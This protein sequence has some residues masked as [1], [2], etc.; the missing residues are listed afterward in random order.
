MEPEHTAHT[1]NDYSYTCIW[2]GVSRPVEVVLSLSPH[3]EVIIVQ[4]LCSK[5]CPFF[6]GPKHLL[7]VLHI[8]AHS[9]F[10]FETRESWGLRVYIYALIS[11]SILIHY[12][13]VLWTVA[14]T[15]FLFIGYSVSINSIQIYISVWGCTYNNY[16]MY[17]K[18][19]EVS[20]SRKWDVHV[21][22]AGREGGWIRK[23]TSHAVNALVLKCF[24]VWEVEGREGERER[25]KEYV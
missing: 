20:D 23:H 15:P 8:N 21:G 9:M 10:I 25:K 2:Y 22:I 4:F 3:C 12:F 11:T 5:S 18:C 14:Y 7:V 16:I 6:V 17:M 24:Y 1:N 19:M 13:V